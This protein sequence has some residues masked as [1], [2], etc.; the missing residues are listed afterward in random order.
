MFI[1]I[2]CIIPCK[3][4]QIF[5]TIDNYKLNDGHEMNRNNHNLCDIGS[6]E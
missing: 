5:L 1:A 3:W 6:N 2:A 4:N